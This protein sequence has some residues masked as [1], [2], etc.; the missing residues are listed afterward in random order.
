MKERIPLMAEEGELA[1]IRERLSQ[2][3]NEVYNEFT[4]A[5]VNL[6][7]RDAIRDLLSAASHLTS[8]EGTS[9]TRAQTAQEKLAS[10]LAKIH[11]GQRER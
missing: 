10:A 9:R 7:C 4:E 6:A 8:S 1:S 5:P 11:D 3:L 2:K